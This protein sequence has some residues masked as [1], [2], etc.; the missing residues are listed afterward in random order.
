MFSPCVDASITKHGGTALAFVANQQM[1]L[2]WL[3]LPQCASFTL[4]PLAPVQP[5]VRRQRNL[6]PRLP[7]AL[8]P[9][10][11]TTGYLN[12]QTIAQLA[13]EHDNLP[14][15]VTFMRDEIR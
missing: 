7:G 3:L 5:T 12:G 14:A 4:L 15:M 6:A 9:L 13:G 8:R 10:P 11:K 2:I 1:R